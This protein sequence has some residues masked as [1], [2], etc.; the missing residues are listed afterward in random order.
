MYSPTLSIRPIELMVIPLPRPLTTPPV[1]TMYFIGL[2]GAP[3]ALSRVEGGAIE[4]IDK[5][6][7]ST[8][9]LFLMSL[10][11]TLYCRLKTFT[12]KV[13]M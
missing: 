7:R 9:V 10:N 8:M 6:Y 12:V 1:T 4:D 3:E 2:A 5:N 13:L 11:F